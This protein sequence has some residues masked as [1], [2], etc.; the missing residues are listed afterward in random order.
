[1][2][3]LFLSLL[4]STTSK[5][6]PYPLYRKTS[7]QFTYLVKKTNR[8]EVQTLAIQDCISHL[9]N[10]TAPVSERKCSLRRSVSFPCS[11]NACNCSPAPQIHRR[12]GDIKHT[13]TIRLWNQKKQFSNVSFIVYKSILLEKKRFPKKVKSCRLK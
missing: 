3:L 11:E 9:N 12:K 6:S 8:K 1:M 2:L 5:F 13:K 4:C 7:C 10:H